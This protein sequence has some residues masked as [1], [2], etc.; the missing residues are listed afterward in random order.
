[1]SC[2]QEKERKIQFLNKECMQTQ[3]LQGTAKD[4]S[5]KEKRA[6]KSKK[7]Q[8]AGTRRGFKSSKTEDKR[9]VSAISQ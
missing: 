3:Q 8:S 4:M 9:P 2:K 6:K 7:G 5:W 1:V